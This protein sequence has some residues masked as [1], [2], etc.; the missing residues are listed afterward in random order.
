[1]KKLKLD[2]D[3]IHVSSFTLEKEESRRGT[4][5]ANGVTNNPDCGPT[6]I[7]DSCYSC[8]P[9]HCYPQPISWDFNC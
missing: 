5:N 9:Q 8:Y 1:M 2:L 6:Q 7:W 3:Q 4:V